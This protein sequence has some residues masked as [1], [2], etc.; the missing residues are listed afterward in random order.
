MMKFTDKTILKKIIET[1]GGEDILLKHGVPC[2]SCPMAK[3]ELDQLKIG[4]VCQMYGL[5]LEKILKDL[6]SKNAKKNNSKN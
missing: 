2:I 3:F 1:P 5:N 6:N 4:Q